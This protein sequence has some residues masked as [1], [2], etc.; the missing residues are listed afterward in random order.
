MDLHE[1]SCELRA[2]LLAEVFDSASVGLVVVGVDLV[3]ALE[4]TLGRAR[5]SVRPALP[6]YL[7]SSAAL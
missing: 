5:F 2:K 6:I 1:R 7:R 4:L 3:T